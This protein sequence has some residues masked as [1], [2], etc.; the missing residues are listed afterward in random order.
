M[1]CLRRWFVGPQCGKTCTPHLSGCKLSFSSRTTEANKFTTLFA[2]SKQSVLSWED[3]SISI[4]LIKLERQK[5][6]QSQC[7]I[8]CKNVL[9]CPGELSMDLFMAAVFFHRCCICFLRGGSLPPAKCSPDTSPMD[10]NSPE[11]MSDE[12]RIWIVK[13]AK[14]RSCSICA[15]T[16]TDIFIESS[17]SDIKSFQT[18]TENTTLLLKI[19]KK[20]HTTTFII[21]IT[22]WTGESLQHL[23]LAPQNTCEKS[24]RGVT[25]DHGPPEKLGVLKWMQIPGY[26]YNFIILYIYIRIYTYIYTY[27]YVYIYVYIRIYTYIRIYVYVYIYIH[28][29]INILFENS[30]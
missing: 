17:F 18:P 4:S 22:P 28:V 3:V 16:T 11:I 24:Q 13:R 6:S 25:V 1:P 8:L 7:L 14:W 27:I 26:M 20:K 29:Y 30:G 23:T 5:T 15:K 19:F 10:K 9:S 21:I 12:V 2:N